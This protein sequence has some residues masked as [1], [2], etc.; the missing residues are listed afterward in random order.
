VIEP[1]LEVP[2]EVAEAAADAIEPSL[3]GAHAE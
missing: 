1:A 2:Q 3:N